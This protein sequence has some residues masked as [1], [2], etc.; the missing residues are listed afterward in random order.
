MEKKSK[1]IIDE[2]YLK[3]LTR[4]KIISDK[5]INSSRSMISVINRSYIYEKV[6][7]TF[8]LAHKAVIDSIVGKSLEDVWGNDA[9]D[10][11]IKDNVDLCL[12]GKE[13]RYEAFI[14]TP[15]FGKKY[16]DVVFRPLSIESNEVTHLL[17]ETFDINELKH[18]EQLII[19]KEEALK[20]FETNLP[21]GFLRCDPDGKIIHA[22]N[23]FL[24]IMGYQD[25]QSI[26]NMN[27]KCFYVEE[28]LFELQVEQLLLYNTKVFGRV[29]LKNIQ[30]VEIPCRIS[31]FLA[32]DKYGNASFI[33]FAI[34]DSSRELMLENRLLQAQKL[35]TIGALAGGIAHDFNSILA[36]IL[37]YSELLY[38]DMPKD[39]EMAKN[40][41]KIKAAVMKAH[42]ITNQILAF[43][44][45]VEQ[46]K[47]QVSVSE[48]L[49]E[50]I[51]FVR[52]SIPPDIKV[53]SN[54][55]SKDDTVLADPTQLFRVFLNL[56]TNAIQSMEEK[57]G[58]L[59]V[60]LD[61]VE[62]K[63]V[64]HDLNKDIVADEYVLLTFK[65]SGKGMDPSLIGR[66]FEPFFTTR[67]IGKGTGLGLSVIHGIITEMEGEILVTSKMG[68]GSEFYIYLPVNKS[69][70]PI[71][72]G[73]E[74]RKKILFIRGN[75]YESKILSLALENTGYELMY[76]SDRRNF[77]KVVATTSERPDLIIFMSDSK[78][79]HPE[80]LISIVKRFNVKTPCILISDSNHE[81]LEEKL[82]NSGIINH[83]LIKPV[84]LKEIR[85][86]IQISLN[87]LKS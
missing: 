2:D 25:E 73:I 29:S 53:N 26:F 58:E 24:R 85:N 20:K 4:E 86:A 3:Y 46:E 35:E 69:Y 47:V 70:P 45:Q 1:T 42:S 17:V 32:P 13:V 44:R 57:G 74:K 62:G 5:V 66:I 14:E 21:I 36:T 41:S 40:V 61:V 12:S 60:N 68:E 63:L 52:S 81:L 75:I 8:C 19:E 64:Q 65:D 18:S 55:V 31:G 43:S 15:G 49:T 78:L 9:F 34:E 10:K 59:S 79:L 37:G 80:E 51:G 38:D 71:N 39:S 77:I 82:L 76:I 56:M 30:G 28:G 87:D 84:S 16:F 6:N 83:H 50:T 27:I 54:I 72:Q 7:T 48:I 67:E 23:A 33:D 11:S 22:N